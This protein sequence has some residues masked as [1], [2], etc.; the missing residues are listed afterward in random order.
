MNGLSNPLIA[1]IKEVLR[2]SREN[3]ARQVNSELLAAYWNIGRIIVEY[4]Q[5]SKTRAEYGTQTLIELSKA[6]TAEFGKGFSRSNLQNMRTFYLIYQKC[7]TV[8][9]KFE[10]MSMREE[11]H[12]HTTYRTSHCIY[13]GDN[14]LI[15][16]LGYGS[17]LCGKSGLRKRC[18][19]RLERWFWHCDAHSIRISVID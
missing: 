11:K 9:G 6:L 5:D 3:V 10:Q 1:E 18:N 16:E 14:C 2:T 12:A 17:V 8:S 15:S 4:E 13:F 7:Q 19:D